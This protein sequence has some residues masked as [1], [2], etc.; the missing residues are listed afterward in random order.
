MQISAI[1][2]LSSYQLIMLIQAPLLFGIAFGAL[3]NT[4]LPSWL[5]ELFLTSVLIY[6]FIKTIQK[7][8]MLHQKE[9]KQHSDERLLKEEK[10]EMH[11]LLIQQ[12][13]ARNNH[14]S[15]LS[16]DAARLDLITESEKKMFPIK[17]V[18]IIFGIWLVVL[19]YTLMRG[20][21]SSFNYRY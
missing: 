5:I 19:L 20:G 8:L 10:N 21:L 14:P 2:L 9:T 12:E 4:I 11:H 17:E 15:L 16:Y 13:R 1:I 7:G 18:L 6:T 3:F